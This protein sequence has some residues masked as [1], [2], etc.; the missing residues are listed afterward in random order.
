[1]GG[2]RL[3]QKEER[4]NDKMMHLNQ[5]ISVITLNVIGLNT[6]IKSET[7]HEWI[8]KYKRKQEPST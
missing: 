6:L 8:Y 7:F 4:V 2:Q 3:K 1:M 5:I